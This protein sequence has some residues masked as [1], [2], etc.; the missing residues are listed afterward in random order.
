MVLTCIMV[1]HGSSI[2]WLRPSAM[3]AQNDLQPGSQAAF[4]FG[5][6]RR[7]LRS[8][9]AGVLL[10]FEV[11]AGPLHDGVG[12]KGIPIFFANCDQNRVQAAHEIACPSVPARDLSSRRSAN[13]SAG[14]GGLPLPA[15]FG[16]ID[17]HPV[18]DRRQTPRH[19]DQGFR[20]PAALCEGQTPYL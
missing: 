5:L 19:R 11:G 14:S 9:P 12:R 18:K 3:W 7:P 4:G 1:S 8:I 17:P 13:S 20:R 2:A 6:F 10:L 15:V 16:V